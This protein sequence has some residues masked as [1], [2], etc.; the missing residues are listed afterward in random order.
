LLKGLLDESLH[1]LQAGE[2]HAPPAPDVLNRASQLLGPVGAGFFPEA[3][4]KDMP[5][6]RW[7]FRQAGALLCEAKDVE[8]FSPLRVPYYNPAVPKPYQTGF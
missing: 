3:D 1:I 7:P 8:R 5:A 2:V 6:G 4:H